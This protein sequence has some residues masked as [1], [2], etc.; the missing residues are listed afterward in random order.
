LADSASASSATSTPSSDS[1]PPPAGGEQ[2]SDARSQNQSKG[3]NSKQSLEQFAR[4]A[5]KIPGAAPKPG[6]KPAEAAETPDDDPEFDFDGEK[7]RKSQLA[8]LAKKRREY[9]RAASQRME[10]AAKIRKESQAR[11]GELR[12]AIEQF[13]ENPWALFEHAGLN[14]DEVA[15]QRLAKQLQRQ[16]MSPEAIELEKARAELQRIQQEKQK[17]EDDTKKSTHEQR[18]THWK[19]YFDKAIGSAL[20]SGSLPRT[21]H[22]AQRMRNALEDLVDAG[23]QMDETAI[24]MAVD[25]ARDRATTETQ[26]LL[27]DL[28]KANPR[29]LVEMLGGLDGE[30]VKAIQRLAVERHESSARPKPVQAAPKPQPKPKGPPTFEEVRKQLGMG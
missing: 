23:H 25:I 6:A 17:L 20:E 7:Y 21:A 10:E 9:D 5:V 12:A 30:I 4:N 18:V 16:Q 14:P 24:A 8:D 28:A 26:G 1:A 27:G 13:K 19:Q 22:T 11:E 3:G 2:N 15:E 29:A